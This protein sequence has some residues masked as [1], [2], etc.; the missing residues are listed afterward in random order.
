MAA[1]TVEEETTQEE[2]EYR[3][4]Q[5]YLCSLSIADNVIGAGRRFQMAL[6]YSFTPTLN[7]QSG[8]LRREAALCSVNE[9]LFE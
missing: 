6:F 9:T 1:T 7:V 4:A 8:V 3:I 2:A 5:L